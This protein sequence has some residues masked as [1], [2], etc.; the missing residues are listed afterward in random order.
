MRALHAVTGFEASEQ[1]RQALIRLG[2]FQYKEFPLSR[3]NITDGD[4]RALRQLVNLAPLQ[5]SDY[6]L[7]MPS[8]RNTIRITFYRGDLA[9]WQRVVEAFDSKR[10]H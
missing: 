8:N 9:T 10:E 4:I 7:T 1:H 3:S 6:S 5:N 2:V